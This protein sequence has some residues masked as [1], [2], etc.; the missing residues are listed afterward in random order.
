VKSGYLGAAAEGLG[1]FPCSQKHSP[2]KHSDQIPTITRGCGI[3]SGFEKALRLCVEQVRVMKK[4]G[5]QG[6][7]R[8]GTTEL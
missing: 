3:F 1:C 4:D 2:I 5:F 6:S 7:G 8:T